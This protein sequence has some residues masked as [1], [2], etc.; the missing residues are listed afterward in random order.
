MKIDYESALNPEQ[1]EAVTTVDG[2]L[3]IVAGAGSGKTTVITYRMAYMLERGVPQH[4]ILA[5]TFTNKAAREMAGR[6]R[7]VTGRKL[8]DLTVSTF[9]AFGVKILRKEIEALGYKANF[10]IYDE[11][12][13]NQLIKDCAREQ[14]FRM[15]AFDAHKVGALF[16]RIRSEQT[17]WSKADD[18]YRG[19][20]DE[21]RRS[22]R[23]FNAV[24]FDDLIVLPIELFELRPEIAERYRD[25]YKY[26]MIDEFQDT[27]L[28]QYR[29]MRL[30]ASGNVC[31]VGDD[32]Q[33]IYSWRGANFENFRL[34]ER[35]FPDFKE[36]KLE[37]N[38]RSTAT[39]LDAANAIIA[40][41]ENRKDKALWSPEGKEGSPIELYA[42][43]DEGAE[44]EFIARTIKE[45]KLRDLTPWSQFGILIR[46]NNLTRRIEEALLAEQVPYRVSGGTSFYGRKEIKDIVS[47]LRV[48]ANPDDDV[49]L[50]RIV[51]TPRRGIGKTTLEK[52]NAI[53]RSHNASLRTA[54]ELVRTGKPIEIEGGGDSVEGAGGLAFGGLSEK[55]VADVS[56]FLDLVG[57][58][59]EE[60]LG[61][62]KISAKIRQ[63]VD[64]IDYWGYLIEENKQSDKA[65]KW[66][67][68]NLEILIQSIEDWENDPDNLSPGL[69]EWLNR[70]SLITR[71]D[72]DDD[73][74]GEVNLMTIHAAKGLEF[75]V[76]FIAG[77]E[78]GIIPHARALEEG[79]GNMEEE[80]R[81]FYV[82]VT[83]ARRRLLVSTC[84]RRK[85]QNQV[86][87]CV[88]SPFL[89]EIPS[90]LM[91]ARE[92]ETEFTEE[93]GEAYF[94]KLKAMFGA[95]A[96]PEEGAGGAPG[97]DGLPTASGDE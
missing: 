86:A 21:Y 59:R 8:R 74:G 9:H 85:K 96:G 69:Y 54:M 97:G 6:V 25:E 90:E 50:L 62:K 36:V 33:S 78:D 71:D 51:N 15:E 89:Q 35:D 13:R 39:I 1:F 73:E 17:A 23:I 38:Y 88:P 4:S 29:M 45:I 46:T 68:H 53:S 58:Y 48:V 44:A 61:K 32:D 76:V 93:E 43:A 27:S 12:D 22:L 5:L 31:I 37:R 91:V 82:A 3:L 65:A 24:D 84:Q 20:Y 67:F 66:K 49:N 79:E 95:P 63:L 47:Y 16:S 64:A 92:I 42:P 30:M 34:F 55:A 41:N 57:E 70:V 87:D 14:G 94:G 18:A 56:A 19:L 11:A 83:R 77:C 52:L 72:L 2:P 60:L 75:D 28:M 80:R 10:S 26:L 7:S 81:L 40:N